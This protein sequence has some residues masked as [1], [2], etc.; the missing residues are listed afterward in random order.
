MERKRLKA[1]YGISGPGI[2]PKQIVD[3]ASVPVEW[4]LMKPGG[5]TW[6]AG[7]KP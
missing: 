6:L 5:S 7:N 4:T 2:I 3:Y 1:L